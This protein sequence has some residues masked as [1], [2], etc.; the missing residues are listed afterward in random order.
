M[1]EHEATAVK[2]ELLHPV[3]GKHPA[4][5]REQA[6]LRQLL[7]RVPAT[8][9]PWSQPGDSRKHSRL[10]KQKRPLQI[11]RRF[12]KSPRNGHSET[13][14]SQTAPKFGAKEM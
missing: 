5:L 12:N 3:P 1:H 6:L 10:Q 9:C 4:Q 11:L 8:M 7:Q 13:K 14:Y 2:S